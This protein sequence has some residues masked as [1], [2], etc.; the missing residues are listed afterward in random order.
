MNSLKSEESPI[1]RT[2]AEVLG[3]EI[4]D[5]HLK[6]WDF[7]SASAA[8]FSDREALV[9]LWQP[10][11]PDQ[12]SP[13]TAPASG[14]LRWTYGSL[15]SRAKRLAASLACLG[16]GPGM[17]LTAIFWNSAEWGLYF[18]AA[19]KLGMVFVPIDVRAG[20]DM[21]FMLAAVNTQVLVVQDADVAETL[22]FGD[23][24]LR[25]PAIR[26]HCSR[27]TVKG[28]LRHDEL[29]SLQ[30]KSLD[31]TNVTSDQCPL[32]NIHQDSLALIIF[33]SGTT[34]IPKGC[35]HTCRNLASQTHEYDPNEDPSHVDRWLVH[36]PVSHI[37][38]VNN[39]L[40]AWRLGDAVVFPSKS[41]EMAST[42]QALVQEKCTIM[43]AT[44]T[45]VKALLAHKDFLTPEKL[46]LSLVTLGGTSISSDDIQ[47]CRQGLGAKDAIQAYGMSEGAPLVSWSRQDT[48]LV[49][50]FHPGI[51]KALPGVS[52]RICEPGTRRVLDRNEVGELHIGGSPVI[53]TYWQGADADSFY[54]DEHGRWLMSGDQ[55][56]L[57]HDGVLYVLGRYKELII[58]GGEN[59]HPARIESALG[60][61]DDLQVSCYRTPFAW[62]HHN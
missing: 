9:S 39:A 2:R 14:C 48:M 13:S 12:Q 16:C 11:E 47:L 29:C 8:K 41:F 45:L 49:D 46:K 27:T 3:T 56:S 28:W 43:S 42:V 22:T 58:R 35:P 60:E 5:L 52:I 55:A 26:I 32:H 38:A 25:K 10:A 53:S 1:T 19:A 37:F 24:Q 57:D 36:T 6:P 18:W 51:G 33:T 62:Y 59:I 4:D 21:Q 54:V 61:L 20:E 34:G 15:H 30:E 7:L 17:H 31:A 40:R 50:G 23:S 44:P